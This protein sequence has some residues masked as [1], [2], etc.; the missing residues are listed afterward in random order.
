VSILYGRLVQKVESGRQVGITPLE[1]APQHGSKLSDPIF[2][3]NAA[4]FAGGR[5]P[6]MFVR[7]P[8]DPSTKLPTTAL[9]NKLH[10]YIDA[11]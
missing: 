5:L 9:Y 10:K 3:S 8:L 11:M 1:T 7:G 4:P 6:R 2:S